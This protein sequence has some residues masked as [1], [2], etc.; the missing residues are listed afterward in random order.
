MTGDELPDLG[1]GEAVGQEPPEEIGS[2]LAPDL[3]QAQFAGRRDEIQIAYIAERVE[4]ALLLDR[5]G[6]GA[7]TR[8][9]S[10]VLGASRSGCH[11][12]EDRRCRVRVQRRA[13]AERNESFA[14]LGPH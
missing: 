10:V 1:T 3:A 7:E 14:T 4:V 8:E 9:E 11:D 6:G 2:V 13:L 5:V 12:V